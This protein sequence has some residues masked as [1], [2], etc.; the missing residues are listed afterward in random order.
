[1][2]FERMLSAHASVGGLAQSGVG[3]NITE[4]VGIVAGVQAAGA[5]VVLVDEVRVMELAF[6][7]ASFRRQRRTKDREQASRQ[8][9]GTSY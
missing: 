7:V 4:A 2:D 3:T 9:T 1:M 6:I 5:M 8:H